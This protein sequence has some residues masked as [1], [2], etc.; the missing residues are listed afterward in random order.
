VRVETGNDKALMQAI[1]EL[2]LSENKF[3]DFL[4][5]F[6]CDVDFCLLFREIE[7]INQNS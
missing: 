6:L 1:D 2:G 5:L 7:I 4:F 3:R